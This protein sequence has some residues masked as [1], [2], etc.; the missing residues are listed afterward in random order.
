MAMSEVWFATKAE[1]MAHLR[2]QYG[3][4]GTGIVDA[5]FPEDRS[6][7]WKED[8]EDVGGF[9]VYLTVHDIEPTREGIAKALQHLPNR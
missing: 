1:A 8:P 2:S 3:V 4:R 5:E 6:W 9:E 7:T